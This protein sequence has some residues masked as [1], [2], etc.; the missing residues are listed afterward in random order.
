MQQ[1]VMCAQYT[2]KNEIAVKFSRRRE[3]EYSTSR[4]FVKLFVLKYKMVRQSSWLA[5]VIQSFLCEDALR[6]KR[7]VVVW[8][9]PL[10]RS[11]EEV[12][13]VKRL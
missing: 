13:F 3:H 12:S 10:Y 9:S 7:T 8:R 4:T 5:V 1:E 6:V 2:N 11:N